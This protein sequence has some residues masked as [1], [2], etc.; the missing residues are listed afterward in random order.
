VAEATADNIF[1]VTRQG[2]ATPRTATNL[3]GITR[4]T[5]LEI[6][7][8]L[9]L[10]YEERPFSLFE[11]WTAREVFVCGTGAEVVPVLSV[12]GRT[13]GSGTIGPNTRAIIN[14]YA[15]LVRSTGTPIAAHAAPADLAAACPP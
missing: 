4:E 7:R 15:R 3:D 10:P 2:L 8:D 6:A 14:E 1:L 11:V 9:G 5:V 13:I 12:D